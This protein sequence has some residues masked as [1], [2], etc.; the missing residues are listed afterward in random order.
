AEEEIH[1]HI[2][3]SWVNEIKYFT[4]DEFTYKTKKAKYSTFSDFKEKINNEQNPLD[5][6]LVKVADDFAAFLETYNS[7]NYGIK[8]PDLEKAMNSISYKYKDSVVSGLEVWKRFSNYNVIDVE[9]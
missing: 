8:S 7:I 5:G 6:P 4:Q 2:R 9:V 3:K 1:P